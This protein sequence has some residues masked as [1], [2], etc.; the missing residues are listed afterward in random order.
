MLKVRTVILVLFS[1]LVLSGLAALIQAANSSQSPVASFVYSPDMPSPQESIMFD[2]STSYTANGWIVQYAWNFGD[3]SS[4]AATSPLVTHFYIADGDYTVQ[5]TVTDNNGYSSIAV[6]IVQ[7]RCVVFFRVVILGQPTMPVANVKVTAFYNNGSAWVKIPANSHGIEIKYDNMTQ[8]NLANTPA[9]KYRNPGYT[10]AILRKNASNI[11][12]DIHAP[13]KEVYF[14]IEWGSYV[15]YWPNETTQVYTYQSNGVVEN[16]YYDLHH[17]AH[18]DPTAQTYVIEANHIAGN[19]VSASENHPIIVGI[20]SPPPATNYYLTVSTSPPGITVIPGQGSY[21]AN[22]NVTLTAPTYVNVSTSTRYRF[23]YWDVDGTSRGSGVNP[24]TVFMNANHTATAHYVQQYLMTF[25]HAGLNPDATGTIVTVNAVPNIFTQ[26][27]YSLWVDSGSSVTYS[28]TS[29]VPSSILGKQFRLSSVS[30]PSSPITVSGPSTITGSY[31]TQYRVTFAHTGLDSTSTGTVLTVNSSSKTYGDLP[32]TL[33][34]DSGATVNYAYSSLVSSSVTGKQF[35]LSSVTGPTS[36]ITV[37]G[38]T[39]VAG[40]FMVQYKLTFSQTGLDSSATGTVVTVDGSQKALTDLPCNIWADSGSSVTYGY[41]NVSSSTTGKRF[42][43]ISVGGTPSPITVTAA[44]TVTGNYKTQFRITFDQTGVGTDFA[45]TVATVDSITYNVVSLPVQ[46]WWD[47]GSSH[48]FTFASPLAVNGSV[49]YSWSSTSG[50]SSLQA[51][52]IVANSAG[53]VIGNYVVQNCVTFDQFGASPDFVGTLVVIDGNNYGVASLPVSFYWQLNSVHTFAFQ[54]PLVVSANSKQYVWT[55]TTGLSS[56]QN[57]SLTVT[58][59]GSVVGTFKTQYYLTLATNPVG[60][61]SPSGAGWYDA[62]TYAA[63]STVQLIDIVPGLSRYMFGAWATA[64]MPEIANSS[65]PSTTVLMDKAK[66]V[67]ANY[68]T[69]Y[70]ISVSQTGVD[71]DF[72]GTVAT[73]DSAGYTRSMLPALFWWNAGSAHT[74]SFSSPLVANVSKQYVWTSTTGL[75]TVQSGTLNVTVS[76]NVN[77]DYAI[78][79]K[80]QITFDQSGIGGDYPGTVLVIDGE[81]YGISQLPISFWWDANSTHNFAYQSPLIVSSNVKQYVWVSTTG[82]S[83]SQ[84]GSLTITTPGNVIGNYKT[85]YYL[86]LETNPPAITIPS[87]SGWYDVG[88]NATIDTAAFI[89]IVP[90]SSRYRFN[91][92]TTVNMAEIQDPARSPTS[93]VMD[94]GKTV[95]ANYAIQYKITFNQVGVATDFTGTILT[96]DGFD[97]NGSSLPVSYMLDKDSVHTFSY[98]SPLVVSQSKQYAWSFT[99]G[100]ST[101]QVGSITVSTAGDVTGH[102]SEKIMYTLTVTATSGGI[103]NPAIGAHIYES[104]STVQVTAIPDPGFQLDYWELDSNSVGANNPYSVLMNQ[105]HSL[106]AYFK[107]IT[108]EM[109]VSISPVSGTLN[110]GESLT[111]NSIVSGGVSPYSYQWCLDGIP[112]GGATSDSWTYTPQH[113]SIHYVCLRVTDSN[114]TTKQ[115]NVATITVNAVPIGGYS[116]STAKPNALFIAIIYIAIVTLSSAI[117]TSKKRK[118]K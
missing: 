57:G 71:S 58:N 80:Y 109:S 16:H 77:G 20:T 17:Q 99:S 47:Q 111:F 22:M 118:R 39:N 116:V 112:V 6:A 30:G 100:L 96:L 2:A 23:D 24:I 34:F 19:G 86:N 87:G 40:N 82:L 26:L 108:S 117:L 25:G 70:N 42:I 15:A 107:P 60:A 72:S 8:P 92:W 44:A 18:W 41:S 49:Q 84:G 65:A 91:G 85:Q 45:G 53:C 74:F 55:A 97:F 7:V 14:K 103:T 56:V 69:Q 106:R 52:T 21:T 5:L 43:L 101:L 54:T 37:T 88:T 63:I 114:G 110:I 59:F 68:V 32:A 9:Q 105:N 79:N 62:S 1:L 31:V 90:G 3:G 36:P 61:A 102:Y 64:D 94:E 46:F 13:D 89:D 11:G 12:F 10:A 78:E 67:T 104:G 83:S 29:T 66:T 81:N 4:I 113:A 38:P 75:T 48:N 95:T 51:E 27:P 76:G 28:Y 93:V 35:K 33:W 73:I 50:L 98:S 115:S